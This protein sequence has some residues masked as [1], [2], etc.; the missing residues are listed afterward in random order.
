MTV[1]HFA[2]TIENSECEIYDD[3]NTIFDYAVICGYKNSTAQSYAENYL[4]KY[5]VIGSGDANSDGVTTVA[6]LV[7]IQMGLVNNSVSISVIDINGDGRFNVFDV[8]LIRRM[9]IYN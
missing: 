4:R 8:I 1:L 9:I 2:I 6:D 5:S 7:H 3:Y